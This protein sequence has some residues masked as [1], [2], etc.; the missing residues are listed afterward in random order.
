MPLYNL[1]H[2]F[3]ILQPIYKAYFSI[4]LLFIGANEKL[5]NSNIENDAYGILRD[6]RFYE[7]KKYEESFFV[8]WKGFKM[9]IKFDNGIMIGDIEKFDV[10]EC[11]KDFFNALRQLCFVLGI[12]KARISCSP[13]SF[14]D[15]L[16]SKTG[17][18]AK[19]LDAGYRIFE[20]SFFLKSMK[21]TP[22]DMD[23]F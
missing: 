11:C 2:K 22:G 7:Y 13:G 21:F 1:L 8:K 5:N 9:W 6:D 15:K 17:T 4:L 12:H 18:P 10:E 20:E 3:K 16:F 23:T 14:A 19:G